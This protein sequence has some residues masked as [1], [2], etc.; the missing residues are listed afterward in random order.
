[1]V[2]KRVRDSE[3]APQVPSKRANDEDDSGSDEDVD[4][5]NVEFEWFNFAPEIDFLGVKTLL[6]QLFDV[7]SQLVDLSALTDLVLSQPTIGSTVKVDGKETDPYAFLTILN[8]QEHRD[9]D[10]VKHLS[11]YLTEKSKDV[12]GLAK[13][14]ELLSSLTAQVGLILTERLI[15]VP[16]EIA[17]PMYAMLIDEI[18][19]AVEDKEPYEFTHYLI[20]SKTYLEIA[21]ALDQ[22]ENPRQKK[23]KSKSDKETFYFHP[24]D[25]VLQRHALG[26]GGFQYT[27]DE[28]EGKADSKRAFQDLGIKPQGHIILIESKKFEQAVSAASSYLGV[29]Q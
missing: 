3:A 6:R 22:E 26:F 23:S 14:G 19:A 5:V 16:S 1:M 21:S 28:G 10:I 9:K 12:P 7:D 24:E 11:K 27:N 29:Q 2:K 18:E 15:N 8:L 13:L 17:P 25:E 4:M 20:L